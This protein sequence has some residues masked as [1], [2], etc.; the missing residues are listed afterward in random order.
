M[1]QQRNL[2]G[3]V[4]DYAYP[5]MMAEKAMKDLHNAVLEQDLDTAIDKAITALAEVK[6][7][8][9]SLR[10]MREVQHGIHVVV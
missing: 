1:E 3:N 8:L 2:R 5:C 4:V 6:L 10:H 7:T 9:N